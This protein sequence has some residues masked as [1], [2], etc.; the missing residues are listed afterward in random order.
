MKNENSKKDKANDTSRD[1][2]FV[3]Y[4]SLLSSFIYNKLR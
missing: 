3:Y 4:A 1:F 2:V